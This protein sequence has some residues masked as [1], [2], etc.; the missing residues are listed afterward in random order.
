MAVSACGEFRA[1]VRRSMPSPRQPS[2]ASRWSL[3]ALALLVVVGV[4]LWQSHQAREPVLASPV[5]PVTH[6]PDAAPARLPGEKRTAISM[7]SPR[8]QRPLQVF[9]YGHFVVGYDNERRAGAWGRYDLDGPILHT[10]SQPPRPTFKMEEKSTARVTTKDYTNPGNLFERG[11]IVPSYALWSRYGDEARKST[12]V[13][14]NV[15]PQDED[16]NGRL[17]EDI[18]DDIAGQTKGGAV[19]DAGY[20]GRLRQITVIAGSVYGPTPRTLPSGI[21]IPDHC[22]HII[23]DL[24]EH[25]GMYRA[26]AYL[27]PNTSKLQGPTSRYLQPIRVIE[28][29]TGLDFMPDGGSAAE[30]LETSAVA[31][32]PW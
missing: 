31:D 24:D 29:V 19:V 30:A 18:E 15:F 4:V 14:T 26:R 9:D 17:W 5:Q 13:M 8:S 23:Y 12:F 28:E 6:A 3:I 10:T 16:L 32:A 21:P 25:T 11:H 22:F 27:I 1:S 2:S 20:A 7:S